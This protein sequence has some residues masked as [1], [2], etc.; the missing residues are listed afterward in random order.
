MKKKKEINNTDESSG[1]YAKWKQSE[2]ENYCI[3]GPYTWNQ[4]KKK[5]A[6]TR[7]KEFYL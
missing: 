6:T 2:K 7:S 5:T 3:D 4:K 1:H